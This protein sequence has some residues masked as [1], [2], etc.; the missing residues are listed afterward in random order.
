MEVAVDS[1]QIRRLGFNILDKIYGPLTKTTGTLFSNVYVDNIGNPR[2]AVHDVIFYP[3]T[4]FI[5][6]QDFLKFKSVSPSVE[7]EFA[8]IFSGWIE[9][10]YGVVNFGALTTTLPEKMRYVKPRPQTQGNF[11]Y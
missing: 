5:L 1:D 9:R 3:K 11:N 8:N 10:N 6:K 7:T 4:V 2:I